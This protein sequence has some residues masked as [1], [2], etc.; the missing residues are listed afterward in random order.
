MK[1]IG[2]LTLVTFCEIALGAPT[3]REYQKILLLLI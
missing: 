2:L 3:W 1:T